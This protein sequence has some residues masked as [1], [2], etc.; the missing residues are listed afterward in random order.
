MSAPRV[1]PLMGVTAS[2]LR[3]SAH[4]RRTPTP[5]PRANPRRLIDQSAPHRA[6]R[7][8][9]EPGSITVC[10]WHCNVGSLRI[11]RAGSRLATS[12][13]SLNGPH[14]AAEHSNLLRCM[15][16]VVAPLRH[17]NGLGNCPLIGED[18]K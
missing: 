3:T 11:V 8:G 15:S 9:N 2:A 18:R 13:N 7:P 17:A 10:P 1:A 14:A 16:P 5:D 12:P 4:L 6:E